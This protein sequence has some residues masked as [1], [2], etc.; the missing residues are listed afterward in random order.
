MKYRGLA[1]SNDIGDI[2]DIDG[3][4]DIGPIDR[5]RDWCFRAIPEWQ[6]VQRGTCCLATVLLVFLVAAAQGFAGELPERRVSL[7]RDAV[8][9]A[10][11]LV[12][13]RVF[14]EPDFDTRARISAEGGVEVPFVGAVV[15]SGMTCH[16]AARR[17]ESELGMGFLNQP[18]VSVLIR[19]KARMFFTI[20]GQV[21]RPGTYRFPEGMIQEGRGGLDLMQALGMAGGFTR[22]AAP[23][24][25]TIR[26]AAKSGKGRNADRTSKETDEVGVRRVDARLWIERA[27]APPLW[28]YPGD[29]ITVAERIF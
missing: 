20:L 3:I 24:R 9:E 17:L 12:E 6:G 15:V 26:R 5:I 8:L 19:E 22:L 23:S 29:V 16:Q 13:I 11:D 21:Q 18:R 28:I 1:G 10:G 27:G 25:V 14:Q 2:G 4:A 7:A